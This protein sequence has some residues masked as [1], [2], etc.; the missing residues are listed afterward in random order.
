MKSPG[1]TYWTSSSRFVGFRSLTIDCV[2]INKGKGKVEDTSASKSNANPADPKPSFHN[3]N[4]GQD[5]S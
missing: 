4:K 2:S 5:K 3:E 1:T